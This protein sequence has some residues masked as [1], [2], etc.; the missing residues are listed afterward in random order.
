MKSS[1]PGLT[2]LVLVLGGVGQARADSLVGLHVTSTYY[3]PNLN[4]PFEYDGEE[5]KLLTH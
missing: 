4:A 1:V 2:A 3:Y 5:A